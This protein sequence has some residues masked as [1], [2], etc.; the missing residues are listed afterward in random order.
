MTKKNNLIISIVAVLVV[1][2]MLFCI[3]FIVIEANHDCEGEDCPICY[4]IS[5]CEHVI[6]ST[7][8][9]GVLAIIVLIFIL[10]IDSIVVCTQNTNNISLVTLKVKLSN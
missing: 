2:V 4:E 7:W 8:Q 9:A 5:V 6:K 1:F 3:A 10:F